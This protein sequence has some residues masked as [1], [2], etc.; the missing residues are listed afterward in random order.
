MH[1][2]IKQDLSTKPLIQ[3]RPS[4]G[5]SGS[6]APTVGTPHTPSLSEHAGAHG[7]R[8]QGLS[9]GSKGKGQNKASIPGNVSSHARCSS[10]NPPWKE[11]SRGSVSRPGFSLEP[12]AWLPS[13]HIHRKFLPGRGS[14]QLR[15]PG[16]SPLSRV[17]IH[18]DPRTGQEAPGHLQ[19]FTCLHI[20]CPNSYPAWG[21]HLENAA[22][23]H[24]N[25]RE[26]GAAGHR[27]TAV[28]I[29]GPKAEPEAVWPQAA[30]L[31]R[32]VCTWARCQDPVTS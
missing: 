1:F 31:A 22:S 24:P 3:E 25:Q 16:P 19:F 8:Y 13:G 2:A 12:Q 28:M 6:P 9:S 18:A 11:G 20:P 29:T 23:L 15:A 30:S 4:T 32:A 17:S 27:D 5:P 14:R 26:T 10:A 21:L 7:L